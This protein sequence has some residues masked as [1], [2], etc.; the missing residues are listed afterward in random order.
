MLIARNYVIA[1]TAS[2]NILGFVLNIPTN[3]LVNNIAT[4]I[5]K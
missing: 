2:N 5:P 3:K 4:T 1:T